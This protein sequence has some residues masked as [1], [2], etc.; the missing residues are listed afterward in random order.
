MVEDFINRKHGRTAIEYPLP[1]LEPILKETYG[2]F[3]YQEQ[4]MQAT[5]VLAGYTLG[6]ADILRRAMGKKKVA[7]MEKQ[8]KIFIKGCHDKNKI[9][10][11]K[12]EA[13]F[14]TLARFAGGGGPRCRVSVVV[15]ELDLSRF[16]ARGS[17][18]QGGPSWNQSNFSILSKG[19]GLISG[20]GGADLQSVHWRVIMPKQC[21]KIGYKME[22]E[23]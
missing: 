3:V 5:N 2:I 10:R 4:V 23:G 7:E 20:T 12:A 16:R 1:E 9:P 11:A 22:P 14:D 19:A 6:G 21:M 18:D 8:R 15:D 13:I 17:Y